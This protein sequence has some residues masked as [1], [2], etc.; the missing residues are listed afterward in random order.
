[1]NQIFKLTILFLV[2]ISFTACA[3]SG[4][5]IANNKNDSLTQMKSDSFWKSRLSEDQYYVL[6]E[7]G[8]EKPFTGKW[9]FHEEAGYYCCAACGNPLFKSDQKFDS[10][11]G[12][13][14]FDDEIEAGRIKTKMDYTL[15]MQRLEIMC[16]NCNGHLGH[17]FDDGPTETGK[18]YCVNSLSIDFKKTLSMPAV[19]QYDT[20]TLGGGCF[21]CIE[22]VYEK[23]KGVVSASSGY[24]GGNVE[25]PTY[26]QVCTG[27]TNHAEVVQLVYDPKVTSLTEILKVFFTMHDPTTLN[28][29]G[30]D[31]GTQYRS[32]VL[33]RNTAQKTTVETVIKD[34]TA[35]NVYDSPIVTEVKPFSV[36]YKAEI[37]HQD[38]YANNPNKGYCQMVIQPKVEKF[39]KVFKDLMK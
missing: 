21:W 33:Y 38:Y 10:H 25:N 39:E 18:R 2:S 35:A 30:A 11:C 28:Q 22:A 27:E 7:K 23:V 3:Q 37:S 24:S 9:L 36:F 12:W 8:T 6:R 20:I 14:S 26:A 19:P 16:A 1:M 13:P 32:V 4:K 5:K 31:F 29:Q 17:L 15:G 34:L